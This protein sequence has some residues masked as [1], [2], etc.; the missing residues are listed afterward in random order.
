MSLTEKERKKLEV[1]DNPEVEF[2]TPAFGFLLDL[3]GPLQKKRRKWRVVRL[4]TKMRMGE[5][6]LN[7]RGNNQKYY[8]IMTEEKDRFDR[9][10]GGK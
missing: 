4:R 3:F 5:L 9:R 6:G 7:L 1:L 2:L 8:E 10:F